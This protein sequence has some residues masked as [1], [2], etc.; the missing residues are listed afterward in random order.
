MDTIL[1]LE[2]VD[3]AKRYKNFQF[4][5][6]AKFLSTICNSFQNLYFFKEKKSNKKYVWKIYLKQFLDQSLKTCLVKKKI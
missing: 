4:L 1:R 6:L 2:W 3:L 5:S